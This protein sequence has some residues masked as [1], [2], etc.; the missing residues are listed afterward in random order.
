ML[1]IS[2]YVK[3][4]VSIMLGKYKS[5]SSSPGV[6]KWPGH[7]VS[8]TRSAGGVRVMRE[9]GQRDAGMHMGSGTRKNPRFESLFC[10]VSSE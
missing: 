2:L 6:K 5:W 9:R 7:P 3:T 1:A 8:E 4:H 10:Y